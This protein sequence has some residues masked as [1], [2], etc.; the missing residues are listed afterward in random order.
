MTTTSN[1]ASQAYR[2]LA[3]SI[4]ADAQKHGT[5]FGDRKVFLS[6]IPSIDLRD[7]ECMQLL[8][9]CRRAGL[10]EFA[11]ADLVA[12]MDPALVAASEWVQG[13]GYGIQVRSHFLCVPPRS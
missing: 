5:Y 11:R 3:Q 2:Y 12:A 8:D 1:T 10:L 13:I 7:A 6:T 4:I 9:E